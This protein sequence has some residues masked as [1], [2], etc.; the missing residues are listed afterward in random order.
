MP[1]LAGFEDTAMELHRI[2]LAQ[3]DVK[4]GVGTGHV[5]I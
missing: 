2:A 4:G 5:A 1:C 3:R